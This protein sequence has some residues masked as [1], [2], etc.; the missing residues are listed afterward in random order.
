MNAPFGQL[1]VETVCEH[2]G[3]AVGLMPIMEDNMLPQTSPCPACGGPIR[4]RGP[5]V[6]GWLS[7]FHPAN[8]CEEDYDESEPLVVEVHPT[9]GRDGVPVVFPPENKE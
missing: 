3:S 8:L 6:R 1:N 2:C 4:L 5:D 7:G 9:E